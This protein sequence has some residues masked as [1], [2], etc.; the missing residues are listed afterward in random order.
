MAPYLQEPLYNE[1]YYEKESIK[2]DDSV[3]KPQA[4]KYVP[5]MTAVQSYANAYEYEDLKPSFPD[6]HWGPLTEV[7]YHDKALDGSPDFR[8]LLDAASDVFDY[9][10]KIGTE[11]HGIRLTSLTDAQKNDLARL[12]ATR[13]V[14]F[15]RNQDD[16]DIEAQRKLGSYFGKLHK[17]ATT[18]V[19]RREGL[20]DVHVVFANQNSKDQRA[21]FTPTFLWHSDVT[22][23]LQP[24]S[25]T[26]LKLLSGPPRG[27]G[28][29]TLWSSQYAAYDAL[30]KPMQT[31]LESLTALHSAEMQ[32]EGSRALGRP[33]RRDP[34]I[35]EHPLVRTHP[36]TG[37]KSLFF[38]PG[39]VTKIVGVPKTESDAIIRYL[40][41][42][43]STTQE[44]HV[45]FQWNKNDVAFW[46]NRISNHSAS[47]GF[48]PHQ[49]HAVRVACHGERPTFD[50]AGTSQEEQLNQQFGLPLVNKD[51]SGQSNYND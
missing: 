44:L 48:A 29:D 11:I 39:F 9:N 42:I 14:V 20:E 35:T 26:S 51:G 8:N 13:G 7:P 34:V 3:Q 16:F 40:N 10:P 47:Y 6:I 15:F 45:R 43:I 30:S 2:G 5:G 1:T 23:E 27:G 19:P 41:E 38:N 22:Y 18:S 33:V 12:I 25:Y 21:Y 32:A 31:Y 46:D 50:P 17:H 49:R 24:P 37:W 4:V 36:V 28:G